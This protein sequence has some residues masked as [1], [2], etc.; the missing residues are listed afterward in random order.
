MDQQYFAEHICRKI[1]APDEF[2]FEQRPIMGRGRGYAAVWD[3]PVD[4]RT[5]CKVCI[6]SEYEFPG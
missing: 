4:G 2:Y 1:L 5:T 6:H 3:T